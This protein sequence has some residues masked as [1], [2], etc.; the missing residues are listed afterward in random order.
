MDLTELL[1]YLAGTLTTLSVVPQIRKAWK[2]RCADDI[3][4]IMV[5]ILICGLSLWTAYGVVTDAWP[6]IVTNGI[7]A[8]LQFFLLLIVFYDRRLK[9]R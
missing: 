8:S 3:S 9:R 6:I 4:L 7:G 1:G 5:V 2:T